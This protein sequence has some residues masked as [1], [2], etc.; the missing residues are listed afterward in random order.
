MF[1]DHEEE[2]EYFRRLKKKDATEYRILIMSIGM[3]QL[4]NTLISVGIEWPPII[5]E[6]LRYLSILSFNFDFFHPECSAGI[7]YYLLWLFM[8]AMPYVMLIPLTIAYLICRI[9]M[10][11]ELGNE[12]K[13]RLMY[14]GYMRMVC[15]ILLIVLPMHFMQVLIP[16]D[17]V[18]PTAGNGPDTIRQAPDVECTFERH[19]YYL[20]YH[21]ALV[22]LINIISL[23]LFIVNAI[24]WSFYW[25]FG[26][27][28]RENLP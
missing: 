17:C 23:F 3:I 1:Q 5:Y 19:D 11:G 13:Q 14:N 18:P 16:F 26:N 2:L 9:L 20:M 10:A 15:V 22:F 28:I 24:S 6:I 8:T 7:D 27:N 21:T 12:M 25:Q 4:F